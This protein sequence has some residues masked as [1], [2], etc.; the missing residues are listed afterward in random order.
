MKETQLNHLQEQVALMNEL[1]LVL[2]ADTYGVITHANTVLTK[3]LGVQEKDLI[4][5][6]ISELM[7]LDSG[8]SEF[9]EVW[10]LVQKGASYK[11][12]FTLKTSMT[13]TFVAEGKF[14]AVMDEGGTLDKVTFVGAGLSVA[15]DEV[16]QSYEEQQMADAVMDQ[17]FGIVELSAEGEIM[18]ANNLFVSFLRLSF[19]Q[20][21]ELIGMN[22]RELYTADTLE[23]Y[24]ALWDKLRQGKAGTES[25]TKQFPGGEVV[26]LNMT[27]VPILGKDGSLVRVAL[28][29]ADVSEEMKVAWEGQSLLEATKN[30]VG[31]IEIGLDGKIADINARG[32]DY[33]GWTMEEVM[34]KGLSI[35]DLFDEEFMKGDR[36]FSLEKLL[37]GAGA[38]G[39]WMAKHKNGE[40]FWFNGLFVPI[41]NYDGKLSK[42][43]LLGND[44]AASS[45]AFE[46]K[47]MLDAVMNCI[48]NVAIVSESDLHGT[49]TKVN[50]QLCEISGYTEE[51]LLG[52]PHNILRHPETPKEV[53]AEMWNTIQRGEVFKATY[54]NRTKDGDFYWVQSSIAP[55]LGLD[56]KPFKYIGVR[57]DMTDLFKQ[58][59]S[60]ESINDAINVANV[61]YEM[62]LEGEL[63]RVNENFEKVLGYSQKESI[64]LLHTYLVPDKEEDRIK[65]E[66]LWNQLRKGEYMV[67][68]F[69]RLS[70][71]GRE[72]WLEGSYNPVKDYNGEVETV[73]VYVQ[74]I[75]ERR[76][77]N[78]ENRGKLAALDQSQAVVEFSV[79]GQI[80]KVNDA[81]CEIVGYSKEELIGMHHSILCFSDFIET[82]AYED[83]W[84]ELREGVYQKGDFKRKA[85]DGEEL[86]IHATYNPIRDMDGNV[87]KVVKLATDV[88]E[89]KRRNA[90][91]RGK[92]KAI[93]ATQL[94]V[95]FDKDRNMLEANDKFLKVTGYSREEL[96]GQPHAMLCEQEYAESEAYNDFWAE[97]LG[98]DS[99]VGEMKRKNKEGQDIW[100]RAVYTPIMDDEGR[101]LKVVKYAD[102]IT[103]FKVAFNKLSDFLE[104]L[105][106][107]N[108]EAEIDTG[109]IE[110]REDLAHMIENNRKMRDNMKEVIEQ[111][112]YV[113]QKAGREGDLSA[114]LILDNAEGA[115]RELMNGVNLLLDSISSPIIELS[116]VIDKL[117]EGSLV[118]YF[119]GSAQGD[120]KGMTEALNKAIRNLNT[121]LTVIN[122]RS[123]LIATLAKDTLNK[124]GDMDRNTMDVYKVV[125]EI[126]AGVQKQV[127]LTDDSSRMVDSILSSA[128]SME[129]KAQVINKSAENGLE[130]CQDGKTLLNRLID[131]IN[132]ISSSA[133]ST[134]GTI[135]ELTE[136]SEEISRTLNVITNIAAQTNLLALNAAIEAA[137]AG[138]AGRGFAVVA[139][140][141]RKLAEDSRMSAVNIEKVIKDV[142][143][144]VSMATKAIE[145]MTNTVAHGNTATKD[146][147]EVFNRIITSNE[148][149]L[150]LSKEVLLA[151]NKQQK[152]VDIIAKNIEKIVAVA[153][154]S[155]EGT[156]R[157]GE[158]MGSMSSSVTDMGKTS[159]ALSAIA[160]QLK[161][162]LGKFKL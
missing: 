129:D 82:G 56:G 23:K 20:V 111:V 137:R 102:D 24:D 26:W 74:D 132:E 67:A 9:N 42:V 64:G 28:Y 143:K 93:D 57:F 68:D 48:D 2:D 51:E 10:E 123:D 160:D 59:S 76:L 151:S 72:V 52:Q 125:E 22:E 99:V 80:E 83:F 101:F 157:V 156:R 150:G 14:K 84:N 25:L 45:E 100:L 61:M 162:G 8:S 54:K 98:G 1:L 108:F 79:S 106:K 66:T 30:T 7:S 34:E 155:S 32:T 53:F 153:E 55:V 63:T 75:T 87:I 158:V 41:I 104:E 141:I 35:L 37:E 4:G 77:R 31:N 131:N 115:W 107:G 122:D 140:E 91:N 112:N 11:G 47:N 126:S 94:I 73:I 144:D 124:H 19:E 96:M 152:S 44:D 147:S 97:I 133:Q 12:R 18:K 81:F 49:I 16:K 135:G 145:Q 13:N 138:D 120:V 90:E 127:G 21:D 121:L 130:Y 103:G 50:D 88:T 58:K 71:D 139:E 3:L 27:Y 89:R 17:N 161:D 118:D 134:S 128:L 15:N 154:T 6:P 117:S 142:H 116:Q 62:N 5:L 33:W 114:T 60:L 78:A 146:V 43:M 39:F 36:A 85:K 70:K 148:E 110:L 86:F 149:T 113:V 105:S 92:L 69:K 159:E 65:E 95:E 109:S 119:Y 46:T 40:T 38:D 136:R 29:A